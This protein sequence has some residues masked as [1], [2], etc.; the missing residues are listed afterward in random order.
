MYG[1]STGQAI[2]TQH[3]AILFAQHLQTPAKRSVQLS[4]TSRNI[5]GL[6]ATLLQRVATCWVLKIELVRMTGCS[7][8]ECLANLVK[9]LQHHTTSTNVA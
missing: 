7:I 4:T 3:I 1:L 2:A 5:V 6:F 9:R 8:V